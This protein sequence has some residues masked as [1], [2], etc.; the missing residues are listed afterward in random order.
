MTCTAVSISDSKGENALN[1][2]AVKLGQD[3]SS[4]LKFS[5]LSERER[6]LVDFLDRCTDILI[7]FH[8]ARNGCVKK[9][10]SFDL[11]DYLASNC[12]W[13]K[14]S[15]LPKIKDLFFFFDT[16]NSKSL[17]MHQPSNLNLISVGRLIGVLRQTHQCGIV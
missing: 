6:P 17:R 1:R 4:Y 10:E 14:R 16:F 12:E 2:S 13:Y 3:G 11:L 9:F 7:P 15:L 8:V 5:Q